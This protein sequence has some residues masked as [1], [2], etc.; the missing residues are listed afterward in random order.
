MEKTL[1]DSGLVLVQ[2]RANVQAEIP[3]EPE[4]RP[5]KRERRPPPSDLGT[6]M[7]QVETGKKDATPPS[8]I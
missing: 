2:T 7:Q 3:P 5:A 6:P 8:G 4:F 1:K